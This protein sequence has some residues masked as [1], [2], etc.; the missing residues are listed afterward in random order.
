MKYPITRRFGT[1]TLTDI[2]EVGSWEDEL[3]DGG[4]PGTVNAHNSLETTRKTIESTEQVGIM[5]VL[6]NMDP[7]VSIQRE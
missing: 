4:S 6:L 2:L 5:A 1:P 3:A 7:T